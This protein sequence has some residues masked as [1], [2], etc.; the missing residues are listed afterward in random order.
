MANN[1]NLVDVQLIRDMLYDDD[2][3]VKEFSNASIQSFGEFKQ[4]FKESLLAREMDELRR[5]GHK[6]KPVAMMLKLDPVIEMYDTSKTYLEENRSTEELADL[7]SDMET[8][9]DTVIAEF[10]ELV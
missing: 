6:I 2:G 9:C 5:A 8:Y 10:Q 7:A 3:Y 4:H 1:E